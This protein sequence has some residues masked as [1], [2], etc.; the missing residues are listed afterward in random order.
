MFGIV[1]KQK[2][3]HLTVFETGR[4]WKLLLVFSVLKFH[5]D[6][7]WWGCC[8]HPLCCVLSGFFQ[9]GNS[10]TWVLGNFLEVFSYFLPCIFCGFFLCVCVVCFLIECLLVSHWASWSHLL[11]S[12]FYFVFCSTLTDLPNI[13]FSVFLLCSVR[14]SHFGRQKLHPLFE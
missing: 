8:F 10:Y 2:I 9:S 12:H 14:Q 4:A 13:I 3:Y 7:I 6:V 1:R 5:N 11:I